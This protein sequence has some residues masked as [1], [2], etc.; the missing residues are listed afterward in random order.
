M[1]LLRFQHEIPTRPEHGP[2]KY[3]NPIYSKQPPEPILEDISTPL[4]KSQ[5]TRIQQIVGTLLYC[6]RAVDTILLT[7]LNDIATQQ[8]TGTIEISQSI[9]K[10]L[11]FCATYPNASPIFRTSDIV[12]HIDSD[13]S[14]LSLS[15]ARSRVGGYYYLSDLSSDLEKEPT[16][17]SKPNGPIFT[18]CHILRHTMAP[19][20]EAEL[21]ALFKNG[22]EAV[23][24]RNTLLNLGHHQPPTPIKTDNSTVA[25]ISNHTI[26]QHTSR[27]MDMRFY[28]VRDRV[29]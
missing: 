2:Y 3:V 22:Q 13:T 28:W 10:L 27:A 14:Y 5:I 12:L 24:L 8:S 16:S 21:A 15:K 6:A 25:G 29:N 20:A 18:V 17:G 23:V 9:T 7:A 19:A 4:I 11:N 26:L 1:A